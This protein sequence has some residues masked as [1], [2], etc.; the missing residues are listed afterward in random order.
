MR[1]YFNYYSV[2]HY[3]NLW[4]GS[5]YGSELHASRFM[6]VMYVYAGW[7]LMAGLA[8]M[9]ARPVELQR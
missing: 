7:Q 3:V 2:V 5:L 9:M 6:Y 4:C 1:V 8:G